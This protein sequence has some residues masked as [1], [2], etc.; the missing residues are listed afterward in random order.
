MECNGRGRP[1]HDGRFASTQAYASRQPSAPRM[2]RME[3]I[4]REI[5]RLVRY[6]GLGFREFFILQQVYF[7][8]CSVGL[9]DDEDPWEQ[10][11]RSWRMEVRRSRW[12]G[13]TFGRTAHRE[14]LLEALCETRMETPA[15]APMGLAC[16]SLLVRDDRGGVRRPFQYGGAGP[17]SA[18]E[19]K[20]RISGVVSK[21][22]LLSLVYG[23]ITF[24]RTT[25]RR[26]LTGRR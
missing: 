3:H 5:W 20:H 15:A 8:S 2:S 22:I 12:F 24:H 18:S 11:F 23:A 13:R 6:V 1:S 17:T 7:A 21:A 25:F 19:L 4:L 26:L 16:Q 10:R 14:R 9:A